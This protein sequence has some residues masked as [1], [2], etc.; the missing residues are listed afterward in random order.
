MLSNAIALGLV[1]MHVIQYRPGA[2]VFGTSVLEYIFEILVLIE[3]MLW[4]C[5]RTRVQCTQILLN[6]LRVHLSTF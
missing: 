3:I 6:T 1:A 5:T 4:S 2:E